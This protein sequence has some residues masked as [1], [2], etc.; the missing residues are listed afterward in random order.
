MPAAAG[1][2]RTQHRENAGISGPAT[3]FFSPDT[4]LYGF[5]AVGH[6]G[7]S[8]KEEKPVSRGKSD[9]VPFSG[10]ELYEILFSEVSEIVIVL[11]VGCGKVEVKVEEKI[12]RLEKDKTRIN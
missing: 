2:F 11:E 1:K 5:L 4:K 7:D 8:R 10:R 9:H 3:E 12:K 6:A